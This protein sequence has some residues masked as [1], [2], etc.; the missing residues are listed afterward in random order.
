LVDEYQ[1]IT[2][3][4]NKLVKSLLANNPECKLFCVGDDWQSI[5]GFA[6]SNLEFFVDF[7]K[8]YEN[9]EITE[10]STN[11]R[12]VKRIVEAGTCLM[13][14]NESCQRKKT[15][16]SKSADGK[17]IKILIS[18]HQINYWKKYHYQI[19]EDCINRVGE[20]LRNGYANKD[21][22][23]LSRFMWVHSNGLPRY[24]YIIENLISEAEARNIKISDDAKDERRVRVLTVHKAKGLEAKV[25]FI[26]NVIKDLYGFPCEIEDTSILEP[27]RE[28]YPHQDR[29]EEERRL[30]YVALSRAKEDL[31]IYTWEP[32]MSEFLEEISDFAVEERLNY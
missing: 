26:L 27:A 17:L 25:V 14:N 8:Y 11:Y 15:V 19:A 16:K 28:N 32:A 21:I 30:F 24:H 20:Y 7:E 2:H 23:I 22:L 1:D 12:S 18:P 4:T 13:K 10:I 31:N 3:Q 6:G 29:K 9:P 5:M